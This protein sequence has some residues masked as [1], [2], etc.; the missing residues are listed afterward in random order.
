[1]TR[2]EEISAK[3]GNF[4]N[5]TTPNVTKVTTDNPAVLKVS[6]PR[7]EGSAEFNGGAAVIAEG[8]AVLTVYGGATNSEMYSVTVTAAGRVPN[9]SMPTS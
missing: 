9:S 7:T 1:V 8:K 3:I 4:L 6:Q 5:V 2:A